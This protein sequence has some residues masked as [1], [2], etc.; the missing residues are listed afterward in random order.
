MKQTGYKVVLTA[1]RTL[2][3]NYKLLFDGMLAASQ[4]SSIPP[5][6]T[7]DLLM[8]WNRGTDIR[9]LTAPLGLR[10]I[11]AALLAGGFSADEVIVVD[12]RY[13]HQAIGTDTAIIAVSSGE[14]AGHG[15]N[16]STMTEIAGGQ[17][18]P[19]VMFERLMNRVKKTLKTTQSK[20][21]VVIGGPGAWQIAT[22]PHQMQKLGIDH[23]ISGYAEGNVAELFH[24]IIDGHELD[25]SLLG[26]P[27]SADAVPCIRGA[28]SMGV[29]EIS[30]GCGL[31]CAFCTIA[32]VPMIHLPES[33]VL[34]DV[35][36]NIKAGMSSI[37]ILSE[38]FFRYG[39][40]GTNANP[41]AV[42]SLLKK[43]RQIEGLRLI[44]T[45]H[46]NVLSISQFSDE[47]LRTIHDL[48]VGDTGCEY[49]WVNVGV[50]TISGELLKANGGSVK[51]GRAPAEHWG[52]FA[53][54]QLRRLCKAGFMP[55]VSLVV[56]L[57][58]ENPQDIQKT[59]DWVKAMSDLRITV[60][61][62]LYAPIDGTPGL[63]VKDMSRLHWQLVKA[64]YKLNFRWIPKMYWDNQKAAG[65]PAGRR[66]L[67]QVLGRG[68]VLQ[69]N[70]LFALHGLRAKH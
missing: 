63:K 52:A 53:A 11:E 4:T 25:S 17:I 5:W 58:G 47:Q 65:V 44:Q 67:L 36:T 40:T 15:M 39:A 61:P 46:A 20:A 18:F 70:A 14:P 2:M 6:V 28:S 1:D 62:V 3:A 56:G 48:L 10:R 59:V 60:F 55:M 7:S 21:K 35:L 45:D 22:D 8:P 42:I 49:P 23:V 16:S 64:S 32:R 9:A 33:T 66:V 19:L 43:L 69:W 26:E 54:E 31:G 68:Q 27:V 50:E 12:E 51:M 57:P 41:D 30:R 29:V 38:D 13:L 37:A 34:T 24:R